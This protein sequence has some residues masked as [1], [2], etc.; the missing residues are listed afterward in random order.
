MIKNTVRNL[1]IALAMATL[2]GSLLHAAE[3]SYPGID[4]C[5][6]EANSL[7]G[8]EI[9]LKVVS[10]RRIANGLQVKLSAQMDQDNSEFL[11]CWVPGNQSPT[12]AESLAARVEPIPRIR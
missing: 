9:Q 10:K 12:H 7:Y 6:A 5:Q 4:S 3:S 1:S 8:R 11:V 2:P